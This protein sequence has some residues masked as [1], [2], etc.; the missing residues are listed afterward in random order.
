MT[1]GRLVALFEHK[2]FV[3]GVIWGL[4]P[5]DQWGVEFAKDL[6]QQLLPMVQDG[7]GTEELDSSS[8]GLIAHLDHLG[9]D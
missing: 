9:R 1:L 2:V 4:N 8:R 5:F 6:A 3:E 7:A